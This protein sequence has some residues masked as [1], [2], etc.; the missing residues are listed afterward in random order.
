MVEHNFVQILRYFTDIVTMILLG[1][2]DI[3]RG[4]DFVQCFKRYFTDILAM[5]FFG[6]MILFSV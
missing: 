1:E 2:N 4:Y 6:A 3:V 5:I